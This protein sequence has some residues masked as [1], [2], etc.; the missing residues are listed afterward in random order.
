[1][2]AF[3]PEV[4]RCDVTQTVKPLSSGTAL[5]LLLVMRVAN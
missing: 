1:M 2:T 4:R 5:V 3:I